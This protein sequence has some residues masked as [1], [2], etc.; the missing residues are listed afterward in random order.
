[1]TELLTTA[2]ERC[3]AALAVCRKAAGTTYRQRVLAMGLSAAEKDPLSRRPGARRSAL[4]LDQLT[5]GA[6]R[7]VICYF[8]AAYEGDR[9]AFASARRSAGRCGGQI[10]LRGAGAGAH[11]QRG[12]EG[13]ARRARLRLPNPF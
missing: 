5:E 7:F 3:G 1:M 11:F 8:V 13:V 4:G 12:G 2:V 9:S 10:D 6:S